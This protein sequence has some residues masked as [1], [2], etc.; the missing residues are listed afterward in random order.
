MFAHFEQEIDA[1]LSAVTG[2]TQGLRLRSPATG[3]RVN[4]TS[5][6]LRRQPWFDR[7]CAA[8]RAE[9][10]RLRW[11]QAPADAV[12]RA[13]SAYRMLCWK[14]RAQWLLDLTHLRCT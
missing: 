8:A 10:R 11:Q 6:L 5:A 12:S 7:E 2:S 14:R 9:W 1:R 3:R 4:P 13:R